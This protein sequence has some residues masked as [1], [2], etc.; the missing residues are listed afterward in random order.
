MLMH[1]SVF[2]Q[3]YFFSVFYQEMRRG[4]NLM[5]KSSVSH[6]FSADFFFTWEN[7]FFCSKLKLL[8]F[9]FIFPGLDNCV[10][11]IGKTEIGKETK[12]HFHCF[13]SKQDLTLDSG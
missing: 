1:S 8:R 7:C 10:N 6:F 12:K 11:F 13:A 3:I 5:T 4:Q 2:E 9:F